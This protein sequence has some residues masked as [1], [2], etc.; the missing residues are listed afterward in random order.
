MNSDGTATPITGGG[1]TTPSPLPSSIR[2]FDGTTVQ[3]V[4]GRDLGHIDGVSAVND[5]TVWTVH[6]PPGTNLSQFHWLTVTTGGSPGRHPFS[7]SNAVGD[8]AHE[9]TWWSLP[10]SGHRISV[11]VGSCLQWHGFGD[12]PLNLTV[13]GGS[14]IRTVTL[15]S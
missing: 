10:Q 2:L 8:P 12:S 9:I 14:S 6:V 5:N 4:A 7:L 13:G 11:Q 1:I 15:T 3:V